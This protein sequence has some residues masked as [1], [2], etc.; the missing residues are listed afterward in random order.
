MRLTQQQW[1]IVARAVY[2]VAGMARDKQAKPILRFIGRDGRKAARKGVHPA[3]EITD[4]CDHETIGVDER[5]AEEFARLVDEDGN[6]KAMLMDLGNRLV[7]EHRF[8][9]AQA[10]FDRRRDAAFLRSTQM[11]GLRPTT[12]KRRSPSAD[13]QGVAIFRRGGGRFL[14]GHPVD[15][16]RQQIP[17]RGH[18]GFCRASAKSPRSKTP[19]GC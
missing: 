7:R 13:R 1:F 11:I 2:F 3:P 10:I 14:S 8:T 6:L 12:S 17:A 15:R 4:G 18:E 19:A 16:Q 9:P 5:A